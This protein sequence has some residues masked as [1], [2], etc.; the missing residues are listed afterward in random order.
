MEGF[1][2][3]LW[4]GAN[5]IQIL[6]IIGVLILMA[7]VINLISAWGFKRGDIF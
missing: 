4:R 2:Q 3:V 7:V 5:F 1:L 6:P